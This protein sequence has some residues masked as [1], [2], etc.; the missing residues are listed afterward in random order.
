[1][2]RLAYGHLRTTLDGVRCSMH[3]LHPSLRV[4]RQEEV[5]E[6]VA[7]MRWGTFK[8]LLAEALVEHLAPIQQ[9]YADIMAD[10]Q[11]LDDIL[12][13]ASARGKG[14]CSPQ[15]RPAQM[16]GPPVP[17]V[18]GSDPPAPCH[19]T[20]CAVHGLRSPIPTHGFLQ[21]TIAPAALPP[22]FHTQGAEAAGA[23]AHQT[24]DDVKK[25]MG[26]MLPHKSR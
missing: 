17:D 15:G 5:A 19:G 2:E 1:M 4:D 23:V 20:C 13:K 6:E 26:F 7:A 16:L 22:S 18:I 25:A 8:P 9:R 10:P 3:S 11:T 24:L 12:E 14:V 21:S